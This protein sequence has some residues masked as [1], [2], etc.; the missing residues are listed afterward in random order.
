M[1]YGF[2]I[3]KEMLAG[4]E[5][6][7]HD[8]QMQSLEDL[9]GKALPHVCDWDDLNMH[10]KVVAEINPEKCIGCQLCY[11]ACE[12]GAHQAIR[13]KQNGH[14]VPEIIEENCVGC[15]LCSHV[16]PVDECIT[17]VR[18]DDGKQSETWKDYVERDKAPVSFEDPRAG[19]KGH[20]IP[21]PAEALR[22]K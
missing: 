2:R 13:V 15:N 6:Y 12:D 5:Q 20:H 7:M 10:Y 3:V 1:H 14:R 22:R 18:S 11:I 4:L 8:K 19:G 17:M 9:V 21:A 16:C